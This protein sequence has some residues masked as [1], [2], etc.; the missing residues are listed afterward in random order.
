M[1][2]EIYVPGNF[3]GQKYEFRGFSNIKRLFGSQKRDKTYPLR[4]GGHH[5]RSQQSDELEKM[6]M[7]RWRW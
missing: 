6:G 2:V 4:A 3:H 5:C 7:C 1:W